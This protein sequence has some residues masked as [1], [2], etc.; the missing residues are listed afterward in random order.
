MR[1]NPK[2][3]LLS[4]ILCLAGLITPYSAYAQAA[5]SVSNTVQILPDTAAALDVGG[6]NT[7]GSGPRLFITWTIENLGD[8]TLSNITLVND[9]DATFGAGNY[10]TVRENQYPE[11]IGLEGEGTINRNSNYNGSTD[12]NVLAAGSTLAPGSILTI[13]TAVIVLNLTDQGFGL[14]VYQNQATAGAAELANDTTSAPTEFIIGSYIGVAKNATVN[15]AEVTF[16]IYLEAFGSA[17]LSQLSLTENLDG[18]FGGGD[19]GDQDVPLAPN[20]TLISAPVL[21]VDP[22]TLILNPGF[23]GSSD[24]EFLAAGSTLNGGSTAQ[25]QFV[26]RVN[27]LI[28]QGLGLGLGEYQNE[29]LVTAEQPNGVY[30]LDYSDFGTD[31]DPNGDGNPTDAGENDPTLFTITDSA[32][33]G[34]AKDATVSDTQVTI[35]LYL[36]NLGTQT[37]TNLSLIDDLDAVFGAGNYTFLIAPVLIDDPGTLVLNGGYDGS[38]TTELLAAGSSLAA[39]DTAQIQF[40][41]NISNQVDSQ[42]LGAGIYQNQASVSGVNLNDIIIT[43]LS[44]EGTDPDPSGDGDPG[45]NEPTLIVIGETTLGAALNASVSGTVVTLD[46]YLENLGEIPIT[47]I[48]GTLSLNPVFGSGNY[49]ILQ[50]PTLVEGPATLLLSPQYFGFNIYNQVIGAAAWRRVSKSDSR[51][52]SVS[53]T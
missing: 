49:S 43:D 40:V 47:N 39:G 48:T 51:L 26:V 6:V 33:I 42:G 37:A 10:G 22:G 46:F 12:T 30:L 16:D 13:R 52:G 8:V 3:Y 38:T 4:F 27:Q 44:T 5:I 36:E 28:D 29:V 50:Q 23:D 14:G 17:T 18:V 11:I 15:G 35:D 31:P 34:I 19:P 9:L 25:I 45:E 1:V 21:I 24:Q 32:V 2:H 7:S 20:Y 53:I 41:V